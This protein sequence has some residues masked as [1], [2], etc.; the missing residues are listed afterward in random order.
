MNNFLF[1][2]VVRI[3]V[4]VIILLIII[5]VI[6]VIIIFI[7]I[8]IIPADKRPCHVYINIPFV[9]RGMLTYPAKQRLARFGAIL[10]RGNSQDHKEQEHKV[11]H[12]LWFNCWLQSC[13][14]KF[15]LVVTHWSNRN[16]SARK[17]FTLYILQG[18]IWNVIKK[19]N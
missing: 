19:F 13:N 18:K 10:H 14:K 6:I 5:I 12:H 8:R 15:H 17:S 3:D 16:I 9:L 1:L 2:R 11:R 7:I 4:V